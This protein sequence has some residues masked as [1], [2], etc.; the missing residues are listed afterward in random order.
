MNQFIHQFHFLRPWWWLAMIPLLLIIILFK[1][2]A[3]SDSAW[4]KVC[5]RHLLPHLL[6]EQFT[7]ISKNW[8]WLLF[9]AWLIAVFALAGPTWRY[10]EQ[11]IYQKQINRIIVM[12]LTA[13]SLATDLPPSRLAREK[14]KLLD[15]LN[16]IK[17]GQVGLIVYA[18]EPYTVSPL[19]NDAKTIASMANDLSPQI[20]PIQGNNLSA[21]LLLAKKL[22]QQAQVISGQIIV[23]SSGDIDV[24]AVTAAKTVKADGFDVSILGVGTQKQAPLATTSG[25]YLH[26]AQ[27]NIAFSQFDVIQLKAVAQAGDGIYVPITNNNDDV[28]QLLQ[29]RVVNTIQNNPQKQQTKLWQDEGHWFVLLLLP[30]VLLSFRKNFLTRIL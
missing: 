29:Y 11:P 15:L 5:D 25:Q 27:G 30:L 12:D 14:F 3:R 19:T 13:N 24:A 6:L 16:H 9:V 1:T 10:L 2:F 18:G 20:M 22:F 28:Q 26:N 4:E 7:Q 21:G 17:E 23:I 8:L